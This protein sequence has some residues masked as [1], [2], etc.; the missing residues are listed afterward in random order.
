MGWYL[1]NWAVY[2]FDFYLSEFSIKNPNFWYMS[3]VTAFKTEMRLLVISTGVSY[4]TTHDDH[5]EKI[6]H[7]LHAREVGTAKHLGFKINY[8]SL[9]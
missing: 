5:D 8:H 2:E 4:E 3:R 7:G 9:Q 1:R 6:G